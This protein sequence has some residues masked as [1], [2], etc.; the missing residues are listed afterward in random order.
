MTATDAADSTIG[1]IRAAMFPDS[2]RTET[3]P[4]H[5]VPPRAGVVVPIR[6]FALGK[7]R[8]ADALDPAERAALARRLA[9][10]VRP[11]R[12]APCPSSSCPRIPT[13]A[14]GRRAAARDRARRSRHRSTRPPPADATTSAPR[15]AS[16]VVVAHADLPYARGLARLAA[17]GRGRSSRS[18]PATATTARRCSRFPPTREFH[19]AY[20][21][22][23]F[24]RHAAEARRLGLGLRV[25]RDRDLAFD[26]DVPDDLV[27]LAADLEATP[28]TVTLRLVPSRVLAIGAHPDDIE[29]GCGATLAKWAR[30][31]AHVELAGPH[32]RLEGH[33]GSRPATSPR[34]SPP[35]RRSNGPRPDPRC[36]PASH[37]LGAVDGE[38]D[39][40]TRH[41]RAQVC[42]RRSA[43][44]VPTS[45]SGH[46]PW[47]RYRLHPDH[48]HG[49]RARSSTGIVAARDPH[50]FPGA[51]RPH[52]PSRLLLF[53]AQDVDHVEVVDEP[54]STRRSHALL[55]HRSQ[56]RSTMGIE[57]DGPDSRC[58]A[59]RVREHASRG[60]V[61]HGRRRGVQAHR[62]AT[63]LTSRRDEGAPEGPFDSIGGTD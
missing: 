13:C 25:V 36:A 39:E 51:G 59:R 18:C 41:H 11:G 31:G 20:G 43:P 14:T 8:L 29:F 2:A 46:D 44:S 62:R 50:F 28:T 1:S 10:R 7:A 24:R 30:A 4:C 40:P 48:R 54:R 35:A 19:F 60:E 33:L 6:A 55:C 23:S 63:R 49:G 27:E 38:L 58:A 26:V 12:R 22:G 32:R 5:P 47:K 16:R 42:A 21:P 3:S 17:T 9:E 57:E 61:A 15:A 56:W 34:W 45:C 37:F 53:E 52:R